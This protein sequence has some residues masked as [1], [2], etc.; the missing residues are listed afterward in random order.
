[1][2]RNLD[3]SVTYS[4]SD[5]ILF[6][7]SPVTSWL[8]RFNLELPGQLKADDAEDSLALLQKL[9][10]QH[11]A[12]YLEFLKE[13]ALDVCEIE[14]DADSSRTL[15]ALQSGHQIV[16]QANLTH[17]PFAGKADFL[18]RIDS[19]SKLGAFSYQV[20]DTKLALSPKP[21]FIIQLCC[22]AEMLENIQGNLAPHIGVILGDN[23][24]QEFKIDD[25]YFYYQKLKKRFLQ[26]QTDFSKD[27]MP[28][29]IGHERLGRWT[30]HIDSLLKESDHLSNVANITQKQISLLEEAK[31]GT[32]TG[33]SQ[34]SSVAPKGMADD[35]Y[36]K[37]KRQARLQKQSEES[38]TP[39]FELLEREY[40]GSGLSALPPFSPM[41]VCFDMEGYP[42]IIGG[43]EYL[44]GVTHKQNQELEFKDWWAHDQTQERLAFEHFIDWVYERFKAD[45]Q[46]H[47]YHYAPYE[48]SAIKRLMG[49]YGTREKEVDELL[50]NKVLVDLFK[51]VRN[52]IV[53]GEPRY[54]I[55]NI[56]HL[57]MEKRQSEV[58]KATDS[59]VFYEKWLTE[60]DGETWEDSPI[61]RSIRDY[62]QEDCDSTWKLLTW[63]RDLQNEN[64]IVYAPE[65]K[66]DFEPSIA[67]SE[68][69]L[70]IDRIQTK[71]PPQWNIE[72]LRVGILLAHLLQFYQREARPFWWAYYERL[73]MTDQEIFDDPEC[74][75]IVSRTSTPSVI[76]K[77]SSIFEYSFDPGQDT[78]LHAGS[79]CR[80]LPILLKAKQ[81]TIHTMDKE[82]GILTLRATIA[83]PHHINLIPYERHDA[84]TMESQIFALSKRYVDDGTLPRALRDFLFRHQPRLKGQHNNLLQSAAKKSTEERLQAYKEIVANLDNSYLCIQGP[85]GSGK[86]YTAAELIV[87]LLEKKKR[88]GITANSHSVINNLLNKVVERCKKSGIAIEAFKIQSSARDSSE[89]AL[90]SDIKISGSGA[91]FFASEE[92]FDLVGGTVYAFSSAD[93]DQKLDYLFIDEASQV[94]L[95][96]FLAISQTANNLVLIGDQMQL[97]QPTK[98]T[99][100]GESGLSALQY[101]M[102]DSA[103]IS[104]SMGVFLDITWR[105]H[106]SICSFI[107][108]AIYEKRLQPHPENARRVIQ[109]SPEANSILRRDS[110]IFYVPVQH[111]NN[112]HSS[113]EE[114]TAIMQI[115]QILKGCKIID[116]G[117]SRPVENKDFLVVSP[118]NMQIRKLKSVLSEGIQIGTVDKFQGMEAPISI[119]SM[120]ASDPEDFPR[121]LSFL[122]SKN[123]LNVAISR[124]QTMSFIV[125]SNKLVETNCHSLEQM[126]LLNVYCRLLTTAAEVILP[127]GKT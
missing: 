93:A 12:R 71:P 24:L 88:I 111:E 83:P 38:D 39:S 78:K 3:G 37:L 97:G 117:V 53:V 69:L 26:F 126:E 86:T 17:H 31:I 66:S 36:L 77:K 33:L 23:S 60:K 101:I 70:L 79:S 20:L 13:Q 40:S 21:Y 34:S 11:E 89:M 90:S 99:H 14:A 75:G 112:K 72:E 103:T 68:V 85:P 7:E 43:L 32:L 120:C 29:L 65:T 42:H 54:S 27:T 51:V 46:M 118:Y 84:K 96:N 44:F 82:R 22:Y 55:K 109:L 28:A 9:G 58:S 67:Q 104:S 74:L 1:M 125:G 30:N 91:P 15:S 114:C 18:R 87:S 102:G 35:T 116:V 107:S 95:A 127:P 61:L 10:N 92:K 52:S 80:L 64:E 2:K 81:I 47:I 57:Y 76:D 48:A 123:R 41:D 63:L 6:M 121:G 16:Y 49:R 98:G 62:N 50:R 124:A 115:V 110:G 108:N 73:K 8:D 119:I 94:S 106:P 113:D 5:L 105:M 56:E 122:F 25:Y 19:P 100:P 45:P 59:V 4:P